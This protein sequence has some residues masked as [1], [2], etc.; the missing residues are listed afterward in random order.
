MAVDMAQ[1][2]FNYLLNFKKAAAFKKE[3]NGR[4]F[5]IDSSFYTFSSVSHFSWIQ[6]VNPTSKGC[7]EGG[8]KD[9]RLGEDFRIWDKVL[10]H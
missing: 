6:I 10:C 5:K 7:V 3:T 8:S 4:T 9:E 1:I 2:P